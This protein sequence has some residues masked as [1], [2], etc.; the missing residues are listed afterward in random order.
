M[1]CISMHFTRKERLNL[2]QEEQGLPPQYIP[3]DVPLYYTAVRAGGLFGVLQR[4]PC[5]NVILHCNEDLG[6]VKGD[7]FQLILLCTLLKERNLVH[8]L[9]ASLEPSMEL[10]NTKQQPHRVACVKSNLMQEQP[11]VLLA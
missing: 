7:I 2:W 3:L 11:S 5:A 6:H 4:T 8:S 1:H 10:H 9:S